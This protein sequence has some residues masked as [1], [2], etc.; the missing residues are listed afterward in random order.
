MQNVQHTFKILTA[1]STFR[2][3]HNF[4]PW[5]VLFGFSFDSRQKYNGNTSLKPL[6]EIGEKSS[7]G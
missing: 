1:S 2:T 3:A 7:Y 6:L 5:H 4:S